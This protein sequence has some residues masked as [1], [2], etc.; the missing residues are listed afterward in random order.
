MSATPEYLQRMA[1][2]RQ[3]NVDLAQRRLLDRETYKG[4]RQYVRCPVDAV[5]QARNSR[6]S[7]LQQAL[8]AH[9]D[10][11]RQLRWTISS[12][13]KLVRSARAVRS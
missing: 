10:A 2:V 12:L 8:R 3:F 1:Q 5:E 7:M 4:L 6:W 11:G 9:T 13:V